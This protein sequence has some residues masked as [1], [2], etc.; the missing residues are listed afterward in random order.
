MSTMVV[1]IANAESQFTPGQRVTI[2]TGAHAGNYLIRSVT[3]TQITADSLPN[4]KARRA[5]KAVQTAALKHARAHVST[6]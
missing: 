6:A 3:P 5:G 2:S 1:D 4:R